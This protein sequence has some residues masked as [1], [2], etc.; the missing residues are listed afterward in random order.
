VADRDFFFPRLFKRFFHFFNFFLQKR[1]EGASVKVKKKKGRDT[2]CFCRVAMKEEEEEEEMVK[3]EENGVVLSTWAK[4]EIPCSPDLFWVGPFVLSLISCS[5]TRFFPLI[6]I[7]N[8]H[9]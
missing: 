1:E 5:R 6:V 4:E 7:V 2:T 8:T 9:T 3:R